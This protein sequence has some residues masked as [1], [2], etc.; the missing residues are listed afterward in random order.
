MTAPTTY[1]WPALAVATPTIL[2]W[3]ARGNVVTPYV[4]A[5]QLAAM[6]KLNQSALGV[7]AGTGQTAVGRWNELRTALVAKNGAAAV[8]TLGQTYPVTTGEDLDELLAAFI[9]AA[10]AGIDAETGE[11]AYYLTSQQQGAEVIS[12]F[13]P[14]FIGAQ[15]GEIEGAIASAD[16]DAIS[17]GNDIDGATDLAS[18]IEACAKLRSQLQLVA[19]SDI[20]NAWNAAGKLAV[21]MDDAGYLVTGKP[22]TVTIAGGLAAAGAATTK[23]AVSVFGDAAGKLIGYAADF[24]FSGPGIVVLAGGGL[25]LLHRRAA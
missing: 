12:Q 6:A 17:S 10:K 9:D 5:A 20:P 25:L 14:G 18:A 1:A 22:P 24:L 21:E 7:A 8:A 3:L 16:W 15:L 19:T 11:G 2:T 13:D 4:T 23:W